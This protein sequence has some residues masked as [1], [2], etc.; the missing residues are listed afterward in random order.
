MKQCSPGVID[1]CE[2]TID[3]G[4]P[5][6]IFIYY[7][8]TGSPFCGNH[9]KPQFS[10]SL[11]A[12]LPN[13]KPIITCNNNNE[14]SPCTMSITACNTMDMV[15]ISF[16]NTASLTESLN[17]E[18]IFNGEGNKL[19]SCYFENIHINPLNLPIYIFQSCM[20]VR[21]AYVAPISKI[22][23]SFF[24]ATMTESYFKGQLQITGSVLSN[25][26]VELTLVGNIGSS[27]FTGSFRGFGIG[28]QQY[29][30]QLVISDE[31]IGLCYSDINIDSSNFNGALNG[32]I[33]VKDAIKSS[34]QI[35]IQR[36]KFTNNQASQGTGIIDINGKVLKKLFDFGLNDC[37][38]IDNVGT[39][40]RMNAIIKTFLM[41]FNI[42]NNKYKAE[43]FNPISIS[44]SRGMTIKGNLECPLNTLVEYESNK[45]ENFNVYCIPMDWDKY[46]TSKSTLEVDFNKSIIK[47]IPPMFQC[48]EMAVCFAGGIKSRG[49]LWG[50]VNNAS[51]GEIYFVH[52]PA[53]HCCQSITDCQSYD[54]C[55]N[56][57]TGALCGKCHDG[58][59]MSLF[60]E[61]ACIPTE[62]CE[63]HLIWL[64]IL[65]SGAFTKEEKAKQT[66][67]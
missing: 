4:T 28:S 9:S 32:V 46:S 22:Y 23:S 51:G 18:F 35:E 67:R 3:G 64:L 54:T 43:S 7:I 1:T 40:I 52:C 11:K 49:N 42:I 65:V 47:S 14:N 5:S 58:F 24:Q 2:I 41:S 39:L 27:N 13:V 16:K 61:Y 12:F 53:F 66:D 48:P 19:S 59:L 17:L 44:D 33:A 20:F 38:F 37:E 63:S 34:Y 57:R 60:N 50:F 36:T 45:N 56:E 25:S 8:G 30:P 62:Q 55:R 21:S 10:L 29:H 26:A 15:G 6:N 31:C